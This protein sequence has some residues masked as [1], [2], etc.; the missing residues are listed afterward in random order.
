MARAATTE[1][2]ARMKTIKMQLAG[3]VI[4]TAALVGASVWCILM[5]YWHVCRRNVCMAGVYVVVFLML[6]YVGHEICDVTDK[7]TEDIVSIRGRSA[8]TTSLKRNPHPR[9]TRLRVRAAA[10]CQTPT[11]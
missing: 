6:S 9:R 1:K 7:I 10:Q 2:L 11:A 3:V 8:K 4:L 5:G